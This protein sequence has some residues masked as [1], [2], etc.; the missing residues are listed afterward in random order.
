MIELDLSILLASVIAGATPIVLAALGE[1]ITEKAGIIN[2]SLDGSI[3]LCAMTAF[4]ITYQ[5]NS[6]LLGFASGALV[7]AL[8][9]AIVAFFS[10]YLGQNQVA[11]GFVLTLMARD[12]AYFIGNPFSR[13]QGLTVEP[14]KIPLLNQIP[15]L[16]TVLFSHNLPV[17]FSLIMIGLCW[18]YIYRTPLGLNLQAV[19]EHPGAAYAR[20]INPRTVQ[21]IYSVCGGLLVGLA[22]ATFSLSTK[23]GWG[24]PQGAEGTGWIALALV[25]FGGWNPVKAAIGAYLFALLQVMGIYL[26][27]W[28][29]SVP[30]QVFQ[31]APF[32]VMIFTLLIISFAQRE[33]IIIRAEEKTGIKARLN[34][35][36]GMAPSA[37]GKPYRPD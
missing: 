26:Q 15:F 5:T 6:L 19:G 1:T 3:L 10:I 35:F 4:A 14:L 32:P 7:G 9:A 12:L 36:S 11:V 27:E 21:M 22:G 23:A 8:I 13:L 20:G 17:Y 29:P 37:L 18:G 31:V 2:L 28:L 30:S 34:F 24:R 25:I 16:G 33:S